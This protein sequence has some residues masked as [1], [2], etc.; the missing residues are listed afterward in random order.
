MVSLVPA[1]STT[2]PWSLYF[3]ATSC[4]CGNE[5]MH[6]PH[7]V[8]QKSRTRIL[9]LKSERRTS[10]PAMST[11]AKSGATA[12]AASVGWGAAGAIAAAGA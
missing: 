8:A 4:V 1:A 7:H 12:P 5:A 9:P 6:G 3:A 2:T 11:V 10:L